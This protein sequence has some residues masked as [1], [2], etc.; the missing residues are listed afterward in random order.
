MDVYIATLGGLAKEQQNLKAK[1]VMR[2]EIWELLTTSK[3][4]RVPMEA[5]FKRISSQIMQWVETGIL[6]TERFSVRMNKLD[7]Q[8]LDLR[9]QQGQYQSNEL[10]A[11]DVGEHEEDADRYH[12]AVPPSDIAF[13]PILIH[14]EV[15]VDGNVFDFEITVQSEVR[16]W[17]K[18]VE[19]QARDREERALAVPR[20]ASSRA[21]LTLPNGPLRFGDSRKRRAPEQP[22]VTMK[23]TRVEND[24]GAESNDDTNAEGDDDENLFL[25][26]SSTPD[27]TSVRSTPV[28]QLHD[29]LQ[30][31]TNNSS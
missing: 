31:Y 5:A 13:K 27:A 29:L 9:W 11:Y 2:T 16:A 22:R 20:D 10:A 15:D 4:D 1:T 26:Q 7:Q 21:S 28:Q 17:E 19:K 3:E 24:E 23:K 12:E 6:D 25:V 8:R 18:Q 30:A 14:D